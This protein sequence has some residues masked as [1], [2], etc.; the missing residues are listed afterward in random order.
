MINGVE[1]QRYGSGPDHV[2]AVNQI[3]YRNSRSEIIQPTARNTA[4]IP[5]RS[6]CCH[7]LGNNRFSTARLPI[8]RNDVF[9]ARQFLRCRPS[10]P[11]EEIGF[12]DGSRAGP[13]IKDKAF[14]FFSYEGLRQ[15]QGLTINSGVPNNAQRAAVTV[16]Q[17]SRN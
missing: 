9:N 1:P 2:S 12:G 17:Q 4:A 15:R 8:F 3:R 13:I 6:L 16:V 5:V 11:S 7:S 10:R 14:F